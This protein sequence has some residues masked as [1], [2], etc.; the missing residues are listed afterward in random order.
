M[1][2]AKHIIGEEQHRLLKSIEHMSDNKIKCEFSSNETI[3]PY[4]R[5]PF[6]NFSVIDEYCTAIGEILFFGKWTSINIDINGT[7]VYAP[8]VALN[9]ETIQLYSLN[10]SHPK[11]V[12]I[13]NNNIYNKTIHNRLYRSINEFKFYDFSDNLLVRALSNVVISDEDKGI[14]L[15]KLRYKRKQLIKNKSLTLNNF[16]FVS[17]VMVGKSVSSD[18]FLSDLY[19]GKDNILQA[20]GL[21]TKYIAINRHF[22]HLGSGDHI[23]SSHSWDIYLQFCHLILRSKI[24]ENKFNENKKYQIYKKHNIEWMLTFNNVQCK[25]NKYLEWGQ[26]RVK[27]L[28]FKVLSELE[29]NQCVKIHGCVI[30]AFSAEICLSQMGD[31]CFI[32]KVTVIPI[33]ELSKL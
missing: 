5:F 17:P 29:M 6:H 22:Q 31:E 4:L 1:P 21:C 8:C 13:T 25:Y 2:F 3:F 7:K 23:N 16:K 14:K 28:N 18:V 32:A 12:I 26:F 33:F 15:A 11:Y 20:D 27:L 19:F 9:Y 24:Y 10:A 30:F